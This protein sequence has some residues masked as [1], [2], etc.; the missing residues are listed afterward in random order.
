VSCNVDILDQCLMFRETLVGVCSFVGYEDAEAG[1]KSSLK[2]TS[3]SK[4]HTVS[5]C[6]CRRP[7]KQGRQTSQKRAR[8]IWERGRVREDAGGG[9]CVSL[10]TFSH[11]VLRVAPNLHS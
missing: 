11:V 5:E 4:F 2:S 1:S 9:D 10:S 3:S 6:E 7:T 8:Y